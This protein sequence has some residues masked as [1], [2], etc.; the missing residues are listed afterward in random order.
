MAD[1]IYDMQ[2][3]KINEILS[4]PPT[5]DNYQYILDIA[6]DQLYPEVVFELHFKGFI[7]RENGSSTLMF[8][9]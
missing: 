8:K 2:M 4:H 7:L 6:K 9:W 1:T 3:Q 5:G